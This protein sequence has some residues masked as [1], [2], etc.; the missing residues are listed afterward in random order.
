MSVTKAGALAFEV[1]GDPDRGEY[2]DPVVLFKAG[3]LPK[4]FD[5]D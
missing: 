3:W 5:K 1:S 4:E 2:D